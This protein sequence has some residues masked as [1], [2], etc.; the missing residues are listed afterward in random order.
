MAT[1]PLSSASSRQALFARFSLQALK[2]LE[3]LPQPT[4]LILLTG[5]LRTP[6]HL[7]TAMISRHAHLL[8]IG[9]GSVVC[10]DL[11]IV[12]ASR[13]PDDITPFAPEPD[14]SR[15]SHR[16][17]KWLPRVKLI[18][19][20]VGMAWHVVAMRALA[21]GGRPAL[22]A[23]YSMGGVE[24]VLRMFLWVRYIWTGMGFVSTII[25]LV[26]VLVTTVGPLVG[27][28]RTG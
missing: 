8:G 15:S 12:L 22:E 2:S 17:W 26:V 27:V 28:L 20:G 9:R 25:L 16:F 4:P 19:A 11:P 21:V 7:H 13:Q 24:V 6:A 10:P 14:L 5:G 23:H 18:G 1:A 3:S